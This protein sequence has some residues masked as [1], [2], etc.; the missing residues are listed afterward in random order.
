[1]IIKHQLY[2]FLIIVLLG[3]NSPLL[4]DKILVIVAKNSPV[5]R[6][7]LQQLENIYRK[8]TQININNERWVPINLIIEDPLRQAFSKKIFK[9]HP[10]EMEAFWN[11]QY[12]NGITP[13]YVVSSNEAVLRFVNSTPNAIGYIH[14]CYL[15]QRVQVLMKLD[16]NSSLTY[17][18][19]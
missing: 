19:P 17:S 8:K 4:A 15:D 10:E 11:I 2:S 9:Q 18:C 16:F 7:T 5:T 13:P 1:M 14:H 12:F 6:L 3:F